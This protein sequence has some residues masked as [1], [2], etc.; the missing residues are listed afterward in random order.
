MTQPQ[1]ILLRVL[2]VEDCE[3]STQLLLLV[4]K[5]AGYQ[6]IHRRV[7]T[8]GEMKKA[9]HDE[10]WDLII[11]DHQMP[12]FD[13][14]G[15]LQVYKESGLDMPF[16]IVSGVIG[17]DFAVAMMKN[18]AHDYILKPNM[19]RLVPSIERE[20]R[21]A[22]NRRE[23]RRVTQAR[24]HLEFEA[25]LKSAQTII[26]LNSRKEIWNQ[27][28]RLIVQFFKAGWVAFAEAGESSGVVITSCTHPAEDFPCRLLV[29]DNLR[30]IAGVLE[31]G[32]SVSG[33]VLTPEP[34]HAA[35]LPVMEG[36][37]V[38]FVMLVAHQ[39][40]ADLSPEL[41]DIY[42]ASANLAGTAIEL[43][44]HRHHLEEL[45][46]TRTAELTANNRR[47]QDEITERK[48]AEN[49]LRESEHKFR[50][51]ADNTYD[52][53][54]WI[55][56]VGHF[57]YCSP[58]CDRIS[59]YTA[60]QFL[61][62]PGLQLRIILPDDQPLFNH[63]RA[64]ALHGKDREELDFRIVRTDGTVRHIRH[65]CQP[66][67]DQ[68][69]GFMGIRGSNRD[70]TER[71]LVSESL[72]QSEEKFRLL[73]DGAPDPI[74]L[75]DGT[76]RFVDC[77]AAAVKF[78]GAADK[79]E[80]L[81]CLPVALSPEHQP[82][83]ELSSV[84]AERL[85]QLV[86]EQGNICFEWVHRRLD[87]EE[88]NVEVSMSVIA[89]GDK[90]IK[91]VHWR[92]I[93]ER[94]R[95]EL[96][97]AQARDAALQSARLKAEFLANMSHEIRTPMNGVIGMAG[98]L[99]D[100]D[101]NEQQRHFVETLRLSGESLLTIINDILDFSKIEARK[102]VFETIDFDLQE[103]IEQA[104][105]PMAERAYAKKLE[106][107]GLVLPDVPTQLRGDP[108]RLRQVLLN[109]IGNAVKFTE[110][111]EVVVRVSKADESTTRVV[112]RIEVRD[113][114]VGIPPAVQQS[115]FQPFTQAD[116]ST[117][118]KYGGSGL[119]LTI[120]KQLVEMM[121]GQIGV[122]S[123][124]GHGSTFWFTVRLEKQPVRVKQPSKSIPDLTRVRLLIVDDNATNREILEHHADAWKMRHASV[125][126]GAEALRLLLATPSDPFD[127]AI[128]D[129]QM[130][131]MDGVM[132]ARSIKADTRIAHTR[133]IMLS[134]LGHRLNPDELHAI[135]I[136]TY[137]NKPVKQSQL[138]D[139]LATV[140][141][142][143]PAAVRRFVPVVANRHVAVPLRILLAEDNVINQQV[144]V[145][146]LKNL[147]YTAEVVA[148]GLEVLEAIRHTE[149]DVL[150]LDCQ[151]PE[152]DGYEATKQI[153][154]LEQTGSRKRLR[155]IAMT[156]HAMQGDREVCL[157]AGM[158]DYLSKPVHLPELQ[159]A[160]ERCV[161]PGEDGSVR[162]AANAELDALNQV[163]NSRTG[164]SPEPPV[165]LERLQE[166][167]DADPESRQQLIA[168]YF[169]QADELTQAMQAALAAG[170]AAEIAALAHK[171][172]GSSASCGMN[173][174][175]PALR[176]LENQAKQGD[177]SRAARLL[178]QLSLSLVSIRQFLS[179][180]PAG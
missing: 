147:G 72:R 118:R 85:S 169:S 143:T 74:L 77:N 15:A 9:L 67:F 6:P 168:L 16:I 113:T 114:G 150:L 41:L 116:G 60:Q 96:E 33:V 1:N 177:L 102:L 62:D 109:L 126:S 134:S 44:R 26:G 104:L 161:S 133:L 135:G 45:V 121:H 91:L 129:L 130:P 66:V 124:P 156:A 93:T 117:T 63:H 95:M 55:N 31:H 159:K 43:V 179:Q 131:E 36:E 171:L 105:E 73:F 37:R 46:Q 50:I 40:A 173:A 106:L 24:R 30:M 107:A 128:L 178:E 155:I 115:I 54:F 64:R 12:R 7:A 35:C 172:A 78:L 27:L 164:A 94:K 136:E 98:L 83:G 81:G 158:D 42:Q 25:F 152:M 92:D 47:L 61:D 18:G 97:L 103:T 4:L 89:M 86:F 49:A 8:A 79:A 132:L 120:C 14:Q 154:Q 162:T 88:C 157:A 139:C 52:W 71:R 21:E 75:L 112:L 5:H 166:L 19:H 59:G 53:E 111:G 90:K 144:A 138:F 180:Q 57:I 175:V 110:Q 170:K 140:M 68:N 3:T 10:S 125:T 122:K 58:S 101:L 174:V 17:E 167:C 65:S 153:R 51:V 56:P 146:Q 29:N 48:Q 82:D 160:L 165:D 84:K 149:Y 23:L 70:I 69:G 2:I 22:V 28:A 123:A 80:V 34:W 99:L 32:K 20:L 142:C 38:S 141:G 127:L 148:N 163:P 176:S 137:L 11:S 76:N 145:G 100:T 13:A 39:Q 87:G 151:M 108:G 119:G